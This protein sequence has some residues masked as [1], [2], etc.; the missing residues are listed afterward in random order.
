MSFFFLEQPADWSTCQILGTFLHWNIH[1]SWYR[2]T[3]GLHSLKTDTADK[4]DGWKIDIFFFWGWARLIFRGKLLGFFWEA[5]LT[6]PVPQHAFP[7]RAGKPSHNLCQGH[8]AKFRGFLR[9]ALKRWG[10][11]W[12]FGVSQ[13]VSNAQKKRQQQL[14]GLFWVWLI[15]FFGWYYNF[16]GLFR[17]ISW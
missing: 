4:M 8:I 6:F 14:G 16:R 15:I 7:Y 10:K 5:I 13:L 12:I 9:R 11:S 17:S 1:G 3:N 2:W